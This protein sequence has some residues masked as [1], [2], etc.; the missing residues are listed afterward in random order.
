M[1]V[2]VGIERFEHHALAGRHLAELRQLAAGERAGV[3]V[4]EQP[5][6][7]ADQRAHRGEV[8]DGR[9]VSVPGEPLGGDGIPEL[10]TLAEGEQ[11][12]V[13]S[14]LG[15]RHGDGEHL[16]GR[17]VRRIEARRRLGERA[18]PALVLAQH[19]ERDE[20]LG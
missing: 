18:V 2:E 9:C 6:L 20:H 11:R 1:G 5:G 13:A 3:G 19:R 7:V 4:G 15:A 10:R 8:V 16:L 17:E 14:D 12:L